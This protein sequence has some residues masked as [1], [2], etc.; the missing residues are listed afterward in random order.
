MI[1]G[2]IQAVNIFYRFFKEGTCYNQKIC[3][4]E[5]KEITLLIKGLR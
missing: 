1:A 2:V 3:T 4:E 5:G